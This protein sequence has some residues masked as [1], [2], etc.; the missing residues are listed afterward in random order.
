MQVFKDLLVAID[1][2]RNCVPALK[3]ALKLRRPPEAEEGETENESLK[4]K[5]TVL[6]VL[7]SSGKEISSFRSMYK[8]DVSGDKRRDKRL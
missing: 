8:S 6:Y 1:L 3:T 7:P 4:G 2:S 5:L